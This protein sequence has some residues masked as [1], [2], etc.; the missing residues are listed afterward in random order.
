[1]EEDAEF[2]LHL[3]WHISFWKKWVGLSYSNEW[4]FSKEITVFIQAESTNETTA[5]GI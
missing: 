3:V 4:D 5:F 2:Y 1:M